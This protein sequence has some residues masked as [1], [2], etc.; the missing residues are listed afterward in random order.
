ML[1][2]FGVGEILSEL[3][4]CWLN[5][6]PGQPRHVRPLLLRVAD[7]WPWMWFLQRYGSGVGQVQSQVGSWEFGDV[8]ML[9]VFTGQVDSNVCTWWDEVFHWKGNVIMC[10]SRC[11]V[12]IC[13]A[14]WT[15]MEAAVFHVKS[16]H[17]RLLAANVLLCLLVLEGAQ[18]PD[19]TLQAQRMGM[20][21]SVNTGN[22]Y[23][24]MPGT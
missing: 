14:R 5:T 18:W 11:L 23:A 4:W 2:P 22:P 24:T 3:E 21:S 10:H 17:R 9:A 20:A 12:E 7:L 1:F 13:L 8:C 15:K 19:W 6:L 16:L